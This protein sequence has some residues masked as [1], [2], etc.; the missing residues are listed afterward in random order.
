MKKRYTPQEK[1]LI[2]TLNTPQK[3]QANLDKLPYNWEKNGDTILSFREVVAQQ[4]AHCL[5]AVFFAAAVLE[6]HGYPPLVLDLE[7]IDYLD[8]C[9]FLYQEKGLF[10][11]IGVSRERELY[12]KKASFSSVKDLVM[13]YYDDYIDYVVDLDKRLIT[14]TNKRQNT[15][16]GLAM[17]MEHISESTFENKEDY[18][19]YIETLK[20]VKEYKFSEKILAIQSFNQTFDGS[21]KSLVITYKHITA[22]SRP[23]RPEEIFYSL[24]IPPNGKSILTK[25]IT[26]PLDSTASWVNHKFGKCVNTSS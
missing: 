25:Y 5:E 20:A 6:K 3:V 7:S 2:T 21:G 22:L 10:G 1:Q 13:S 24:Y 23:D 12:G 16:V 19:L 9:L 4:K 26:Q 18:E 17:M 15:E 14:Y 8:H 11:A